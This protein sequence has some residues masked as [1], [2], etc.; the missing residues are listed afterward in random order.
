VKEQDSAESFL[1]LV[2]DYF[3]IFL[4]ENPSRDP[5]VGP[6]PL[7]NKDNT[8]IANDNQCV[9][10]N[11]TLV[12]NAFYIPIFLS[13]GRDVQEFARIT[14]LLIASLYDADSSLDENAMS[15]AV[16]LRVKLLKQ[17]SMLLP[18][19]SDPSIAETVRSYWEYEEDD[20]LATWMH[21][22]EDVSASVIVR[23]HLDYWTPDPT[24]LDV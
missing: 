24:G 11:N 7:V 3:T 1:H 23:C 14:S 19:I 15:I 16:F 10:D 18:E 12:W 13:D 5:I 8:L 4:S 6:I 21:C 22:A 9:Y 17:Q 20:L 2:E